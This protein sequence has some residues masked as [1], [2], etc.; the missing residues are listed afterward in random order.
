MTVVQHQLTDDAG[1]PA[2]GYVTAQLV[3]S[4]LR[5]AT[6]SQVITAA[7]QRVD[8]DGRWSRDLVPTELGEFYRVTLQPDGGRART[9]DVQVPAAD[10]P[11]WLGDLLVTAPVPEGHPLAAFLRG[12]GFTPRGPW[13]PGTEYLVNDIVTAGGSTFRVRAPHTSTTTVPTVAQPGPNLELWAAAGGAGAVPATTVLRPQDFGAVGDG[14]A[15]DSTAIKALEAAIADGTT[16]HF[17]AGSYRFALANPA[18]GAALRIAGRSGVTITFDPAAELLMD[19]L[20]PAGHGTSHGI[21]VV[22]AATDIT[23]DGPR[24]R[25]KTRPSERSHGE[26]FRFLGYPSDS[27]PPAGWTGSTGTLRN[28]RLLNASAEGAPQTG[29]IFLGCSDVRVEGFRVNGTLADALHFNACRRVTVS[30]HTALDAG[31]DGLAF[32]TY[33]HATDRWADPAAG[34]FSQNGLTDWSNTD[35]HASGIVVRGGRANGCR[36]AGARNLQLAGLVARSKDDSGLKVDAV[37]A[38]GVNYH[39]TYIASRGISIS[40]VVADDC[41]I[42]AAF[43]A[44]NISSDQPDLWWRFDVRVDGLTVRNARN[45]SVRTEGN[46][47]TKSVI[48]GLKLANIAITTGVTAGAALFSSLRDSSIGALTMRSLSGA[49]LSFFGQDAVLTGGLAGLASHNVMIDS[50]DVRGARVLVQDLAD[51]SVGRIRCVDAPTDGVQ[52][53][54]VRGDTVGTLTVTN[55]NRSG[56]TGVVRAVLFAGVAAVGV[57]QVL[58]ATDDKPVT[59]LEIGGGDAGL[60]A[61]DGLRIERVTY[62]T[63]RNQADDDVVTQGGPYGPVNYYARVQAKNTGEATP[64]WRSRIVGALPTY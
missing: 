29:A 11:V 3:G 62:T 16:V 28:V 35:S 20:D 9:L 48:A 33:H 32:V 31:D 39:W 50:I 6:Q 27:A 49:D 60:I 57:D 52:F 54:R 24:V 15:D 44:N 61:A 30:G 59:S 38:D 18:G 40:D 8:R 4:G 10:S 17:P 45:L 19:N 53:V 41:G 47:S 23:L 43:A 22:G 25:W 58:I 1:Q 34:P 46:G 37:L 56:S 7:P 13:T 42:G 36:I 12:P 64:T 21:D 63:T 5:P 2:T 51:L 55:P 26:A 14:I